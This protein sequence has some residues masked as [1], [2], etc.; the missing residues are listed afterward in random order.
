[1]YY[2]IAV[3]LTFKSFGTELGNVA[4][5]SLGYTN[6]SGSNG[7]GENSV[8]GLPGHHFSFKGNFL[9]KPILD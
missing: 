2:A 5:R 9:L 7:T 6:Q 3:P 8:S 4:T 1:M